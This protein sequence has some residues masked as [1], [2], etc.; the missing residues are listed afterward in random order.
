MSAVAERKR[1]RRRVCKTCRAKFDAPVGMPGRPRVHCF[2]CQP[3]DGTPR[4]AAKKPG[5][6]KGAAPATAPLRGSG[7]C[8]CPGCKAKLERYTVEHW[9]AWA[10]ELVLDSGEL[11]EPEGYQLD[12]VRDLFAGHPECWLLLPEGNGKTTLL[13]A[14][15]LYYLEHRERANIG[16]AASSREQADIGYTQAEVFVYGSARLRAFLACQPGHRR[17]LNRRDRGK[18]QIYAGDDRTGDGLIPAGICVLDEL[19]RHRDMRLYRVWRGK[20]GKRGAQILAIST[21]GEPGHE[22]EDTRESIR[23]EAEERDQEG[24]RLRVV[25]GSVC[26][27]DWSVPE[28]GDVDDISLVA[29]ANPASFVTVEELESKRTSKTMT[30]QHW[31]RF[32]CN[33]ATRSVASAVT[34]REWFGAAVE[35]EAWPPAGTPIYGVGLDVAWVRD[36]TALVPLHCAG[37]HERLLGRARIL[38]PARD[39]TQLDPYEVERA[40]VELHAQNPFGVLVMDTSQARDIAAWAAQE[41]GVPVIDRGQQNTFAVADYDYFMEALRQ[42]WLRHLGDPGMNRHVFNARSRLLPGGETRFDRPA[43]SRAS[44]AAQQVRMID[45]LTAAAMVHSQYAS[46]LVAEPE[47][48]RNRWVPVQAQR[49]AA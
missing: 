17:I 5:R 21:A 40:L 26:M 2:T 38:E 7:P 36:S 20:L 45:A 22:F 49:E 16:W 44:N 8:R 24:C 4:P 47:Q 29:E 31:R 1:T 23:Q 35:P 46:E 12:F 42:G 48:P 27:H 3:P 19:H 14:L 11:F 25:S 30:V 33:L 43:Q 10:R 13:A 39:G 34:E 37:P 41:F 32:V 9:E 18:L 28:G 6:G 15:C